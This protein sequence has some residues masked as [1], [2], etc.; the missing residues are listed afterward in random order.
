MKENFEIFDFEMSE[1]EIK[2]IDGLNG[3]EKRIQDDEEKLEKQLKSA[4]TPSDD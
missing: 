3:K 2:E 1:E 4:P